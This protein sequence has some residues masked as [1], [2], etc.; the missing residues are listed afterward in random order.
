MPAPWARGA[1]VVI[2]GRIHGQQ[3]N[4]VLN[5]ATNTVV[6]DGPNFEALLLQLAQAVLDC[7]MNNLL[8][9]I[10]QDWTFEGVTAQAFYPDH[11][12]PVVATPPPGTTGIGPTTNVSFAASLVNCRTGG[13]GRRG[14]GK[15][16]LP[17]AGDAAMTDSKLDAPTVQF[18][19]EFLLCVA[20]KFLG[21]NPTTDWRYVIYSRTNDNQVLGTF[22]NS[23]REVSQMTP[24]AIV[25][26]LGSRKLRVA[27]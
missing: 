16:F 22:D 27:S 2:K 17:P 5:F 1:R 15:M 21:A 12:D 23:T 9:A 19:V 7:V 8:D 20:A 10:S 3:T 24:N 25:A 13:G 6:N 26:K 14:Q 18:I 11:S 4:N